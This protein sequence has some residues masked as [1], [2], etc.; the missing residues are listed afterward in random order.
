[1]TGVALAHFVLPKDIVSANQFYTA[2]WR[3][4]QTYKNAWRDVF[5]AMVPKQKESPTE[6]RHVV[7]VSYRPKLMDHDNFVHGAKPVVD[8]LARWA[9]IRDDGPEWVTVRYD[10][11]V[12]VKYKR[13]EIFIF[14]P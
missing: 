3:K 10:Q 7:I 2:H 8:L 14:A 6:A 13:T 5:T 12:E 9:Y 4:M 1:M 11:R